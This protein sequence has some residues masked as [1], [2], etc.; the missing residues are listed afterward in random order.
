[1]GDNTR[2]A[3]VVNVSGI[4]DA[5]TSWNAANEYHLNGKVYVTELHYLLEPVQRL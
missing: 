3:T 2:A 1:M 5:N 4:I